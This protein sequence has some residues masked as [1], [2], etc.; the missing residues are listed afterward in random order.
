MKIFKFI[1]PLILIF[2]LAAPTYA[3][4]LPENK[5]VDRIMTVEEDE[6]IIDKSI[7]GTPKDR[8][9]KTV[10][11]SKQTYLIR[12]ILPLLLIFFLGPICLL[13]ENEIKIHK[14]K[15]HSR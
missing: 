10:V 14:K 12:I 13:I 9:A 2:A 15:S 1:L 3:A 6:N 7:N 4:F 8:P 5:V 11:M